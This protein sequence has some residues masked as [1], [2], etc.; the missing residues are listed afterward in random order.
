M[1]TLD[2]ISYDIPIRK[3]QKK[4][5]ERTTLIF[6]PDRIILLEKSWSTDKKVSALTLIH[7]WVIIIYQDPGTNRNTE[8]RVD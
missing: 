5:K 8:I 3:P 2:A 6:K 4:S 7:F 1:V